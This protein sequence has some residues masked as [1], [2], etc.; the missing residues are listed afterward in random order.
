MAFSVEPILSHEST[1]PEVYAAVNM[2]VSTAYVGRKH[3]SNLPQWK[4]GS[5]LRRHHSR[6]SL[7]GFA[8]F[9]LVLYNFPTPPWLMSGV[10]WFSSRVTWIRISFPKKFTNKAVSCILLLSLWNSLASPL[11]ACNSKGGWLLRCT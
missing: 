9:Y 7:A 2:K 11:A 6:E 1:A 3:W 4:F 5:K 8:C 10:T